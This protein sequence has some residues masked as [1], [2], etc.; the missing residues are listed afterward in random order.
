MFSNVLASSSWQC[1][2][3]AEKVQTFFWEIPPP[4]ICPP[5]TPTPHPPRSSIPPPH[6]HTTPEDGWVGGRVGGAGRL[7]GAF[8]F[9]RAVLTFLWLIVSSRAY[10]FFSGSRSTP[11]RCRGA[12]GD[13]AGWKPKARARG[14]GPF[15]LPPV[16]HSSV[17]AS[18]GRGCNL[19]VRAMI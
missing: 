12:R 5:P 9:V 14:G 11:A 13:Q 15:D 4:R 16:H 8:D 2:R 1:S 17:Q 7:G 3:V 6:T 10:T 18:S 19:Q